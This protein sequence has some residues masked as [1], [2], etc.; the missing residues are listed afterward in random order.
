M[1]RGQST[2]GY[3]QTINICKM[4]LK[5]GLDYRQASAKYKISESAIRSCSIRNNINVKR[6][7][8][9]KRYG[10]VKSAVIEGS[11]LGLSSREI[12]DKYGIKMTSIWA[13]CRDYKIKLKPAINKRNERK[14]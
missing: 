5:E 1:K 3:G 4:A 8:N 14:T 7:S 12:A 9:R 10:V 13:T 11:E 2:H 6:V